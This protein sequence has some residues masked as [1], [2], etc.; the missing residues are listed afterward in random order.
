MDD[1][2]GSTVGGIGPPEYDWRV[3]IGDRCYGIIGGAEER[4]VLF[5]GR[6][7]YR[8]GLKIPTL[9][10]LVVGTGAIAVISYVCWE[11]KSKKPQPSPKNGKVSRWLGLR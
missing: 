2:T 1:M 10:A 5:C 4:T 9:L 6:S 3:N 8:V 7:Y 11:R